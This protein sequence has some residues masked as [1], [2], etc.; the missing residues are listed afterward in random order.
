M[1]AV[2]LA[3]AGS[4]AFINLETYDRSVATNPNP[5]GYG[6]SQAGEENWNR[7]ALQPL[8]VSLAD[9]ND[10][11][12]LVLDLE[13]DSV[14]NFVP[15]YV[16]LFRNNTKHH[17]SLL[18]FARSAVKRLEPLPSKPAAQA[19]SPSDN[20]SS[21]R[22]VLDM[23]ELEI[24][25]IKGW[26]AHA[27][28]WEKR[29]KAIRETDDASCSDRRAAA[30]EEKRAQ[31]ASLATYFQK[32]VEE[33]ENAGVQSWEESYQDQPTQPNAHN[34]GQ[35]LATAE[36]GST[37]TTIKEPTKPFKRYSLF[38]EGF[39]EGYPGTHL[40]PLYDE[41][42]EAC[43]KGDND[44][45][46]ALCLPP[47]E[48]SALPPSGTRD[49]LQIT[50]RVKYTDQSSEYANGY[51]P[52]YVALRARKWDS[53]R[54][55]L[56]ISEKQLTKKED[57]GEAK[58]ASRGGTVI[59]FND[60]SDGDGEESDADSCAS[61]ETEKR[62]AG[63]TDLAERFHTVSVNV[64]PN[65]LLSYNAKCAIENPSRRNGYAGSADPI[66]VA[67]LE[68]DVEAFAQVADMMANLVEP[69]TIPDHILLSI[70]AD[71]SPELLD[72]Y[73]RNTG[74]G[75]CLP[76]PK[77][78]ESTDGNPQ[79]GPCD[80]ANDADCR[81]YL[82]LNVNGKKRNDLASEQ[83]PN[84]PTQ[85]DAEPTV[86]IG[87]KAASRQAI[88]IL[89]YL[90]S[91]K[92]IE[93]YRH[94]AKTRNTKLAKRLAEALLNAEDFPNMVG[95]SISR[96][97]ETPVLAA[98]WNPYHRDRILPTLKKLME[99]QPRLTADG[100]RLQV[101]PN[102][103]SAFLLLCTGD[104]PVEAFDWMLANGADPL[105]RDERGWNTFHLMFASNDHNWALIEH[106]LKKLPIDVVETLMAQQ[107][108]TYRN[109]PFAIVV[110]KGNLR[111]VQLILRTAKSA[112]VPTL[113]LR[114]SSGAI[115]LH[116]AIL[117]GWSKIASHII[118]I[119]SLEMLYLEN[120]V[121]STPLEIARLQ[122]LTQTLR[123]LVTSLKRPEGFEDYGV[124]LNLSPA[125]GMRE[126]DEEEVKSLRRV[127][128]GIKTS[129]AL[130]E[131]PEL[132]RVLVNFAD[133]S[134]REFASWVA[135]K[136]I[137]EP[138][139]IPGCTKDQ[140][141]ANATLDVVSHA[142]VQVHRRLLVHLSDVQR[143]VLTAVEFPIQS[144]EEDEE[145]PNQQDINYS[146]I[147]G[148][149]EKDSDVKP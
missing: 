137:A 56:E 54:L 108:H 101:R 120:G 58:I 62:P 87:W 79:A 131:K 118:S 113:L 127:V 111:L 78:K 77:T 49:L 83:D 21:W 8:E 50:A 117:R 25:E 72:V 130:I 91:P 38:G 61:D 133:R 76:N 28:D 22:S 41:L 136:Q 147:L 2:L 98:A 6:F 100:I 97:A 115:P 122:S 66:R 59:R 119:G 110:K 46:R 142:V 9:Y 10:L 103:M 80:D 92:A 70:L 85:S 51:T 144:N 11:Y 4:R 94:Y 17:R 104:A 121:G 99:L 48:N 71:D 73:I 88:A 45:I 134:E 29:N 145:E 40:I 81:I 36:L 44:K 105:V 19:A 12:R 128:E 138:Q 123:G 90:S 67:A 60:D 129:Q 20:T 84:A 53:A 96:L 143:A 7:M 95:F 107:T 37:D 14:Q 112:I 125:P 63:Y 43:W 75:L 116:S 89:E 102:R 26:D 141:D 5:S 15:R 82:G 65:R 24:S 109:T 33:L 31:D 52:L 126:R 114:D 106:A 149:P 135:Q 93:A 30:E 57:E 132:L 64:K 13:P 148:L 86:P 34:G 47:T 1:V 139:S 68:N 69:M 124:K 3:Y 27:I 55:I 23:S 74:E 146:V 39:R 32:V 42:Y 140:C 16:Y 18:D 35:G